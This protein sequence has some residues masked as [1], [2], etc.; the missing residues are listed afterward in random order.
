MLKSLLPAI[1]GWIVVII[2]LSMS[3][4]IAGYNTAIS[5]N[6]TAATNVAY[7]VG[8]T[9]VVQFGGFLTIIAL[10]LSTGVFSF[11]ATR[12]QN[13]GTGGLLAMIGTVIIV[14]FTF[15]IFGGTLVGKFDDLI[16]AGSAGLEKTIYGFFPILCYVA[17]IAA[18]P[19]VAAWQAVKSYKGKKSTKSSGA[20]M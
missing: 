15:S 8:M 19:G 16:T 1:L 20:Y 9:T 12:N 4:T 7:M 3:P 18:A 5:T 13:V 6:V 11:A 14:I 17:M 2:V 10:L